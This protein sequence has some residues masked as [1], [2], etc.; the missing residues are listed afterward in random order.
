M[1]RARINEIRRVLAGLWDLKEKEV[2]VSTSG[3]VV[4]D[5]VT[6]YTPHDWTGVQLWDEDELDEYLEGQG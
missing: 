4:V 5:R 3:R 2:H 1:N 6:Q